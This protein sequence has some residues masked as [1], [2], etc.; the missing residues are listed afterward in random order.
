MCIMTDIDIRA[1]RSPKASPRIQVLEK[2]HFQGESVKRSPV[3]I[4]I[5]LTRGYKRRGGALRPPGL[6]KLSHTPLTQNNYTQYSY[7]ASNRKWWST[8]SHE[9]CMAACLSIA[10]IVILRPRY[11]RILVSQ[12]SKFG[13]KTE[14]NESWLVTCF[15]NFDM[16]SLDGRYAVNPR[17]TNP[18]QSLLNAIKMPNEGFSARRTG[19]F[20]I[21]FAIPY[22][23]SNFLLNLQHRPME[24]AGQAAG[25][26][27]R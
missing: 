2:N 24:N 20:A 19:N 14:R 10:T 9:D 16:A 13:R 8:I 1:E 5:P 21:I 11:L 18:F 7:I 26:F 4:V 15:L 23:S 3:R 17:C 12:L 27:I 6:I 25:H 22:S